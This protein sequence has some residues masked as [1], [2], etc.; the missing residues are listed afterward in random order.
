LAGPK[1]ERRGEFKERTKKETS[2]KKGEEG[3]SGRGRRI[4]EGRRTRSPELARHRH[5]QL[6]GEISENRSSFVWCHCYHQLI[7]YSGTKGKSVGYGVDESD[8]ME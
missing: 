6:P 2:R 7:P 5:V 4:R 8:N 1:R 3:G